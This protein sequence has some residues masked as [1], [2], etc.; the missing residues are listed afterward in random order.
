[1][2]EN[3]V[4]VSRKRFNDLK[5]LAQVVAVIGPGVPVTKDLVDLA[6]KCLLNH[7]CGTVQSHGAAISRVARWS[8]AKGRTGVWPGAAC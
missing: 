3:K 6:K 5:S 8:T 4:E 7:D 2:P 1:M